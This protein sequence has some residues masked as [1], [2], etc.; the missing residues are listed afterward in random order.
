MGDLSFAWIVPLSVAIAFLPIQT[1]FPVFGSADNARQFLSTMWQVEAATFGLSIAVVLFVFQAIYASAGL[2]GSLR[3]FAQATYLFPI[4]YVGLAGLAL[5]G[6]VLVGGGSGAPGGWAATWAT[7]W[8]G[9]GAAA[10]VF[11]YVRT[12]EA[13][14][15]SSLHAY[16]LKHARAVIR[17]SVDSEIADRLS[18]GLLV[19]HCKQA[20]ITIDPLGFSEPPDFVPIRPAKSGRVVD[21]RLRALRVLGRDVQS[22][23]LVQ[24]VIRTLLRTQVGERDA[25]LLVPRT[26]SPRALRAARRVVVVGPSGRGAA[27][28]DL[29]AQIHAEAV[30]AI[31]APNPALYQDAQAVYA[32]L[33]LAV[34]DAW[35]RYLPL[36]SIL[37]AQGVGAP[38]PEPVAH[39]LLDEIQLAVRGD[40]QE[41]ALS[42]LELPISVA[43]QAFPL[44]ATSLARRMLSLFAHGVAVVTSSPTREHAQ[45][46]LGWSRLRLSECGQH[47]EALLRRTDDPEL[48]LRGHEGVLAVFRT[49]TDIAKASVDVRPEDTESLRDLYGR[50]DSVLENWRPA[51]TGPETWDVE[52]AEQQFGSD[53]PEAER[54]RYLA[55]R[56]RA[57]IELRDEIIDART[58]DRF[59]LACWVLRRAK[60]AD[61][62]EDYLDAWRQASGHFMSLELAARGTDLALNGRRQSM[63]RLTSWV[64]SDLPTGIHS[65]A[66]D[67]EIIDAFVVLALNALSPGQPPPPPRVY[68]ALSRETGHVEA[69]IAALRSLPGLA[70]F[71]PSEGL[72]QRGA[73]LVTVLQA[74][75]NRRREDADD[76]LRLT[77]VDV[78]LVTSFE[79][80][81]RSAWQGSRPLVSLL[82]DSGRYTV[83]AE[84]P[85]GGPNVIGQSLWLPKDLFVGQELTLVGDEGNEFGRSLA[86]GEEAQLIDT[87]LKNA[88][89]HVSDPS[90]P[91]A[92]IVGLISALRD[93]GRPPT[94]VLVPVDFQFRHS[95]DLP[96]SADPDEIAR[97]TLLDADSSDR[98]W[99]FID[100]VPLFMVWDLDKRVI[101]ADTHHLWYWRQ[102]ANEGSPDGLAI[103]VQSFDPAGALSL[104]QAEPQ[105]L[106]NS[107][108][109]LTDQQR[110]DL[111]ALRAH[112][113]IRDRFQLEVSDASAASWA[114][115]PAP[116]LGASD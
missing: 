91:A 7:V 46:V 93:R 21:I 66:I 76:R 17:D 115:I 44:G 59:Y 34:P 109:T 70:A 116:F 12:T 16:R 77:T 23:G 11:L 40:S 106:Q 43:I 28:R 14:D 9:G 68:E 65:P 8:A 20:G 73:Q 72:D 56:R 104:A 60:R 63:D 53:S 69:R 27:E 38:F 81:I 42:S 95:L 99:G 62:G 48:R 51:Q 57:D 114:W 103:E 113:T 37:D 15:P 33:L 67:I 94:V 13:I 49:F 45:S 1:G 50:W 110:A 107:G 2:R 61:V 41:I 24:P 97:H 36:Q 112:L 5:T 26:S 101:A 4:F 87:V 86:R 55:D 89:Q 58:R 92:T 32:D 47:A 84:A 74:M 85:P 75:D 29:L 19:D 83:L 30:Q 71:L 31:A 98:L 22:Q 90:S 88:A 96:W 108:D 25:V 35:S 80:R 10:L 39:H 52:R 3:S 100:G 79:A 105:A 54:I 6:V 102:I 18:W 64:L 111:I 78:G 82:K